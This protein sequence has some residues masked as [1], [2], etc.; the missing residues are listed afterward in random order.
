MVSINLRDKPTLISFLILSSL[1]ITVFFNGVVEFNNVGRAFENV[2]P[3]VLAA[4]YEI[5]NDVY[6]LQVQLGQFSGNGILTIDGVNYEL[7]EFDEPIYTIE[8]N[9]EPT[10]I[11]LQD[12]V[13]GITSTTQAIEISQESLILAATPLVC[14]ASITTSGEYILES[15]LFD[16]AVRDCLLIEADDVLLDCKNFSINGN[17]ATG[18]ETGIKV[19]G[20][21]DNLTIQNCEVFDF[22]TLIDLT[23]AT[24]VK[25]INNIMRSSQVV[26]VLFGIKVNSV[27]NLTVSNNYFRW[28][29]RAFSVGTS[30]DLSGNSHINNNTFIENGRGIEF[31][32]ASGVGV[33]NVKVYN[34]LI[35]KSSEY[36]IRVVY[37]TNFNEIYNNVFNNT[38]NF[39]VTTLGSN[40]FSLLPIQ[41]GENIVGG[42]FISGNYWVTPSGD[43]Y[44]ET[45]EDSN[46]DGFCDLSYNLATNNVDL[47]P[48][49]VD[50]TPVVR[51]VSAGDIISSSGEYI[52]IEDFLNDNNNFFVNISANNV[53][54]DC[55]NFAINA[56]STNRYSG[57]LVSGSNITIKNCNISNYASGIT[58]AGVDDLTLENNILSNNINGFY[59]R[60]QITNSGGITNSLIK[61]NVFEDNSDFGVVLYADNGEIISNNLFE[62]NNISRNGVRGLTIAS[63]NGNIEDNNFISNI[64]TNNPAGVRLELNIGTLENNLFRNNL[65][66]NTNNAV[67]QN[68]G[69]NQWS[70]DS[71]SYV[72]AINIIGLLGTRGN[73]WATPS[74]NG[75]SELESTCGTNL[76]YNFCTQANDILGDGTNVDNYPITFFG[77]IPFEEHSINPSECLPN[78]PCNVTIEF[79]YL[80]SSENYFLILKDSSENNYFYTN[81]G[82]PNYGTLHM[83]NNNLTFDV[84]G[85]PEGEYNI[86]I[87]GFFNHDFENKITISSII[88]SDSD[89]IIDTEDNCVEDYNPGQEDF[90]NDGIGD[91]CDLQTCGLNGVEGTEVCDY[92][93][94]NNIPCVPDY[95]AD[96]CY[97]CL[98]D[99]SLE[100]FT[101]SPYCGDNIINGP[102]VC[103][104]ADLDGEN[105]TSQGFP[106]GGV[107]SCSASCNGFI[108]TECI[109]PSLE[110]SINPAICQA[111]AECVVTVTSS[112]PL[113]SQ[114]GFT[115]V[116]SSGG[117][118]HIWGIGNVQNYD[119]E[120]LPEDII[121]ERNFII[122]VPAE[123]FT[124]SV[125]TLTLNDETAFESDNTPITFTATTPE[126]VDADGDGVNSTE[127]CGYLDCDDNNASLWY[128]FEVYEDLDIDGEGVEPTLSLCWETDDPN[129]SL[130]YYLSSNQLSLNYG[131][132]DDNNASINSNALEVCDSV[133]NNCDGQINEG[134]IC[135]TTGLSCGDIISEEGDY[136]L[137]TDI[138]GLEQ[139]C[140]NIRSSN[141]VINCQGHS[142]SNSSIG[143][144][145]DYLNVENVTI[146]N[147]VLNVS[148][149]SYGIYSFN[150]VNLLVNNSRFFGDLARSDNYGLYSVMSDQ[151]KV[152]NSEFNELS[153]GLRTIDDLN[154]EIKNNIFTNLNIAS[155]F[156]SSKH[157]KIKDNSFNNL[158][159]GINLVSDSYYNE[160]NEISGNF[161][162]S[163]TNTQIML[164][165]I[166]RAVR[167]NR[168]FN[169]Y[170]TSKNPI[171]INALDG[172][173]DGVNS[174]TQSPAISESNIVGG[175]F[176][177]GNYYSNLQN[178]GFSD[179]CISE[180]DGT[181]EGQ[182][183]IYSYINDTNPLANV[184]VS[185]GDNIQK[186]GYYYVVEDV[187]N[188]NLGNCIQIS[189]SNV[190]LNCQDY[191]LES[192]N[193]QNNAIYSSDNFLE[194]IVIKNCNLQNWN[195]GIYLINVSDSLIEEN[196][197]INSNNGIY[198]TKTTE[199]EFKNNL[200]INSSSSGIALFDEE[201]HSTEN[202]TFYNNLLNNSVNVNISGINKEFVGTNY[203][204]ITPVLG[205]PIY[206]GHNYVGGN[207][208][209]NLAGEGYSETCGPTESGFCLA[210]TFKENNVDNSPLTGY[211]APTPPPDDD[212]DDGRSSGGSS[213]GG[214]VRSKEREYL[215]EKGF[216][217]I[218]RVRV[219]YT[220]AYLL[221]LEMRDAADSLWNGDGI[222]YN[223]Y[224]IE[225]NRNNE[226]INTAE[227]S[228]RINSFWLE[229]NNINPDSIVVY[230]RAKSGGSWEK[231]P[232]SRTAGLYTT[233]TDG[234]SYF[235]IIADKPKEIIDEEVEE[236]DT[237][238]IPDITPPDYPEEP[239]IEDDSNIMLFIYLGIAV[240]LIALA[241]V[242]L[243]LVHK[244]SNKKP[245]KSTPLFTE[246]KTPASLYGSSPMIIP[247]KPK[248][249][250]VKKKLIKQMPDKK[251]AHI[252]NVEEE[253]LLKNYVDACLKKGFNL[254]KIRNKL[255]SAGWDKQSIDH[256]LVQENQELINERKNRKEDLKHYVVVCRQKNISDEKIRIIL[257]K[258]GWKEVDIEEALLHQENL[259]PAKDPITKKPV[260]LDKKASEN[261]Q[262]EKNNRESL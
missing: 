57:I 106:D 15:N 180:E 66:N 98:N 83:T 114:N 39:V 177:A 97:S 112:V 103:D 257:Q 121:N 12:T 218:N 223:L 3:D 239:I 129:L 48:L 201:N 203:F 1:L 187:P 200:V 41:Q 150:V 113:D 43:G 235:A 179:A 208:Y 77:P 76:Q 170:F 80:D 155:S 108:A 35:E 206:Q 30:G 249:M 116:I 254:L 151:L 225:A 118:I 26:P 147:C 89:G 240:L 135:E 139:N 185:C 171:S 169:N 164:S 233:T 152:Y 188:Y 227:I 230:K 45:C 60:F 232:T 210:L 82:I 234:F 46:D 262:I 130:Y 20:P 99:C 231:L 184:L 44:S 194:N 71:L 11:L 219:E 245:S 91:I 21:V 49:T 40:L 94:N 178:S 248:V 10:T 19:K 196:S 107:L 221:K 8:I 6:S 65:F 133:D 25:I 62:S 251:P 115:A 110:V 61:N 205:T 202:N 156:T 191:I 243:T 32:T 18:T 241:A 157:A 101:P 79:N 222:I 217:D 92:A 136:I 237:I 228:F 16:P 105:C 104:G 14:G 138:V 53:L 163:I 159:S 165:E 144:N 119:T 64:I 255:I 162:S 31:A 109:T 161:F 86:S 250:P 13:T 55:H 134:L 256:L 214:S 29:E 189:S 143:I 236:E 131:D 117:T 9:Q 23:D 195:N 85:I 168:I 253:K 190:T 120:I 81:F 247:S 173:F 172:E 93:E 224:E 204:S 52:L 87:S 193:L 174:F 207:F 50:S 90:D 137:D 148:S 123:M 181:C 70:E 27:E 95:G 149:G 154:S 244:N 182:V 142:I 58:L 145:I 199:L 213:G 72:T 212:E 78:I 63:T 166:N 215:D 220:S 4:E 96:G 183:N 22:N 17:D 158:G 252:P 54:L 242:V 141:V 37:T 153:V 38:L 28:I 260:D 42:D 146:N 47:N 238:V 56:E 126:C 128:S 100:E 67:L 140:L 258:A 122:T 124:P 192:V 229:N 33:S 125:G 102:E 246:Q 216:G 209:A 127:G 51:V 186:P 132:C 74:G 259:S 88:D 167:N 198:L 261:N 59:S 24:N 226:E 211:Q 176:I 175:P 7:T 75:F 2:D 5:V 68:P 111:D 160:N 69:T 73:F 34:N 197:I 84:N 36:G